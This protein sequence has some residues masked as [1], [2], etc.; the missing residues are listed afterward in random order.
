MESGR[1]E[2]EDRASDMGASGQG[3]GLVARVVGTGGERRGHGR[4]SRYME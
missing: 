3:T 4:R 1:D 2:E